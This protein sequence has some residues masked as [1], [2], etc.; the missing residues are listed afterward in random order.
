MEDKG[1]HHFYDHETPTTIH[2]AHIHPKTGTT[3]FYTVTA[4]A[5]HDKHMRKMG[6]TGGK[7]LDEHDDLQVVTHPDLGRHYRVL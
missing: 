3:H 4:P 1:G 2:G 6:F 7:I 5:D